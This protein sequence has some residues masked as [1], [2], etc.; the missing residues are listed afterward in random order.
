MIYQRDC[1]ESKHSLVSLTFHFRRPDVFDFAGAC[2]NST[3]MDESLATPQRNTWRDDSAT[4]GVTPPSPNL[5][6][7]MLLNRSSEAA[8]PATPSPVRLQV[9]TSNVTLKQQAR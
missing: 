5:N 3:S 7:S 8:L 9:N 4:S 2:N 6:F 1:L